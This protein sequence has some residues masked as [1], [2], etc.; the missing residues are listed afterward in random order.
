MDAIR[1]SITL[2][3]ISAERL[4]TMGN[5]HRYNFGWVKTQKIV[6]GGDPS[7][8][9]VDTSTTGISGMSKVFAETTAQEILPP[10]LET[11]NI[12][13]NTEMAASIRISSFFKHGIK[14]RSMVRARA[15]GMSEIIIMGSQAYS[16]NETKEYADALGRDS[17]YEPPSPGR[18]A[19]EGGMTITIANGVS[20]ETLIKG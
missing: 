8:E 19:A 4:D 13:P 2:D 5:I 17:I 7:G 12:S 20:T 15:I 14:M 3:P 1:E 9:V 16:I 10:S 18:E 6:G 11:P